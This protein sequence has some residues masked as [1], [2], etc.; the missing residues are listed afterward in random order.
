MVSV[1]VF[2]RYQYKVAQRTAKNAIANNVV[3]MCSSNFKFLHCTSRVPD[4]ERD[5]IVCYSHENPTH[6]VVI[7]YIFLLTLV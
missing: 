1:I 4:T 5:R 3:P 2:V 6:S 7:R